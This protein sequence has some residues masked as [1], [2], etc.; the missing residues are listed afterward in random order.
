MYG[1]KPH[2][3][4]CIFQQS[5]PS[6]IMVGPRLATK[7]WNFHS[8]EPLPFL[9]L[10]W[11]NSEDLSLNHGIFSLQS[12][13]PFCHCPGKIRKPYLYTALQNIIKSGV[14]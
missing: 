10:P 13:Y 2:A 9:P 8:P 6:K 5:R 3:Q 12:P 7:P 14:I 1:D 11:E 4:E